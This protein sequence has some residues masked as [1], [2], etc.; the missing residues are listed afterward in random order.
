MWIFFF[1]WMMGMGMET[2][3]FL[4]NHRISLQFI[5]N[6]FDSNL[7]NISLACITEMQSRTECNKSDIKKTFDM[8]SL[9]LFYQR[10]WKDVGFKDESVHIYR[11][12]GRNTLNKMVNWNMMLLAII[13]LITEWKTA[14]SIA[15]EFHELKELVWA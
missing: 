8:L 3:N 14:V 10:N 4:F 6:S 12:S 1:L 15:I 9:S 11:S 13:F 2:D 5:F 7:E